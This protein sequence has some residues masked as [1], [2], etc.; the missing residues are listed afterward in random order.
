[1]LSGSSNLPLP[2]SGIALGRQLTVEY[3]DCDAEIIN[4]ARKMEEIF[5]H[6]AKASHA[7]V[8]SSSFHRFEPQGVSGVVVISESHFAVHAWPEYAYAA[9]DIFTC[10]ETIDFDI[11]MSEIRRGMNSSSCIV[12][13][14]LNRGII[15]SHGVERI[16]PIPETE[17]M[18]LF[19]C[20]WESRFRQTG[21]KAFS[22]TVD[23]YDCRKLA[24][25]QREAVLQELISSLSEVLQ[26]TLQGEIQFRGDEF[27]QH[28]ECG[29]ISGQ[30]VEN[31]LYLDILS[32]KFFD[33]R[34]AAEQA[35]GALEARH[36]RMQPCVRQ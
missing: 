30:V 21:G 11:A 18:H 6:A 12:S 28:L 34:L 8:I 13:S 36:Y 17:N 31:N 26:L 7:T 32:R 29:F 35:L 2:D 15:G 1:M 19:Q 22:N 9:V 24:L 4:D 33:P 5:V 25:P 14:M 16:R 23:L 10:G 27:F 3:Y 20:S